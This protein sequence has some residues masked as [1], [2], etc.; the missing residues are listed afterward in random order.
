VR[1][2]D[3]LRRLGTHQVEVHLHEEV[4][5]LVTVEVISHDEL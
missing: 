1:L 2:D 3:P 4:N 5:A